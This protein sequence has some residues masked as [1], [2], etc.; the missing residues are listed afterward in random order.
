MLRSG[1]VAAVTWQQVCSAAS[2][3][4]FESAEHHAP[5]PFRLSPRS[6]RE[7]CPT[8]GVRPLPRRKRG[9]FVLFGVEMWERFSFYG[10]RAIL[11]LYLKCAVEGMANPPPGAVEGFNPG[12]GWLK[13]DANNLMGWYGGMAYLLPILGG[14]I[15]D[16]LIG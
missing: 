2:P 11:G 4:E 16:K 9:L 15:A 7:P 10:M 1:D 6:E 14:L 13:E 8:N 12:R 3:L 5:S